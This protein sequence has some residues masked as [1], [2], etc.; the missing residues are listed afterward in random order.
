MLF[1][2]KFTI[3][4]NYQQSKQ[5]QLSRI[6]KMKVRLQNMHQTKH[7]VLAPA[8]AV[9]AVALWSITPILIT[10]IGGKA[11]AA[12]VFLIAISLS[13]I[14]GAVIALFNWK[15]TILLCS[16]LKNSSSLLKGIM[17]ACIAGAFIG[18]WYFGF[19]QAL[20]FGPKIEVTV[21]AFIWPLLSVIAMR[22]F[23]SD[24]APPLKLKSWLLIGASFVGVG[25]I[26]LNNAGSSDSGSMWGIFWAFLAAVGSGLYL[27]FAVKASKAFSELVSSGPLTTFYSVTVSNV[28][29]LV[30]AGG[31]M[32]L[33]DYPL[34]F[35]G[36]DM[37]SLV[38][39]AVIG[40]GIYLFAEVAWTW[41]FRETA[42]LTLSSLPYFSPA[43]SIVLLALIYNEVVTIYAVIGLVIILGSNL[44]LHFGSSRKS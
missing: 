31:A 23:A 30:V 37:K 39:C 8:S 41:A 14:A 21:I 5:L 22:I 28:S 42:S 27:P 38:L 3:T 1:S 25:L 43:V 17:N 15:T 35:S 4:D 16:N 40:L 13:I 33:S 34:D 44:W 6:N 12:E 36:L 7:T 2:G 9:T 26:T 19:Y 11:G 29:S 10:M 32:L 20:S 24:V 18:L